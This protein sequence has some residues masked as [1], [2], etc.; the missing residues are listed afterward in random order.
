MGRRDT[1]AMGGLSISGLSSGFSSADGTP[2]FC[3]EG[4]NLIVKVESPE[5]TGGGSSIPSAAFLE[6][7]L[8]KSDACHH[9]KNFSANMLVG[10]N[11]LK[12]PN[13]L[14]PNTLG[15]IMLVTPKLLPEGPPFV[16]PS[17]AIAL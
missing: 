8:A 12:L 15:F 5:I 9:S 16:S 14:L 11:I 10:S 2:F 13:T 17:A 6:S 3:E 1:A 7:C 4:P